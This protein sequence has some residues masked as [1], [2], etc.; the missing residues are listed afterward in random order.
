MG[1]IPGV[2]HRLPDDKHAEEKENDVEMNGVKSCARRYFTR[3]DHEDG[4]AE[5]DLPDLEPG[6]SDSPYGDQE[7]NDGKGKDGNIHAGPTVFFARSTPWPI[8]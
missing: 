7:K 1:E 2:F 3:E 6:A 5:H 8:P 4:A